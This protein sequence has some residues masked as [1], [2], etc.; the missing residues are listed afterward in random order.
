MTDLRL[1]HNSP[2]PL[3]AQVEQLLRAMIRRREYQEGSL[4]PDEVSL[5]RRL[6]VSRA[7]VRSG[8]SRLV[9][10]GLLERKAGV[11]TRVAPSPVQS[12]IGAWHSFTHE[13][14]R[15]GIAVQTFSIAAEM[16]ATDEETAAALQLPPGT[17]VLRLDRVRGWDG[18]PVVHFRSWL[19]PRLDLTPE[20]DFRDPLYAVIERH[21]SVVADRSHEE[22]NAVAAGPAMAATLAVP[23]GT[24]LLLRRRL[25]S[26]PGGNPI[27]FSVVHYRSD[28]FTLTM[29]IRRSLS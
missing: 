26:D 13:M 3:H 16:A 17:R 22:M 4:L 5:A 28:R 19:H 23:A 8:I 12:G 20:T 29:D 24:P 21:A 11:G 15:M 27:E 2:V 10:E 18:E 9:F 25:V 7:T 6:G 14:E 1:D